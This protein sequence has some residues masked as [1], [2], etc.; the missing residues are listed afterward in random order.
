MAIHKKPFGPRVG[1]TLASSL[2]IL[3]SLVASQAFAQ[4]SATEA[5]AA[6]EE[7][8]VTGTR[9]NLQNAQD[10]KRDSST[11]VDVISAEDIG[12]L[13]DRSVLEAM[14]RLPGVSIERFAGPDDPDHFSVEG[15]GAVIRGMSATRS[16]FNGRDSFTANSG[17]GLSFQDVSPELMGGVDVYKNQTADMIEGGIGG[18]VSL[19]TRKPFDQPDQVIAISGDVS[20]GDM[21]E[22]SSP[23]ISGLYSNQWDTDAGRFGVLFNAANSRL[24]GVSHGIQ[25]DAFVRYDATVIPGAERFVDPITG[26]GSVWMPNGANLLM[27]HDDRKRQGYAFATQWESPDETLLG[28][29]QY[30]RSDSTLAWTENA[31]KYQGGYYDPD[32]AVD[33]RNTRPYGDTQFEF[34]DQGLFEQGYLSDSEGWRVANDNVDHIPRSWGDN[35]VGKFGHK[36][37]SETRYKET[38][39]LVEDFSFNFAWTPNEQWE[40]SV[41]FQYIE[42]ETRDD[43]LVVHLGI[44]A[45]QKY[46]I[47]GSTPSLE[48]VEPWGGI[49]DNARA[50]DP[51][52]Y[53]QPPSQD[54]DGDGTP[55][56]VFTDG[57]PGFTGD[58]AGDTN[59]F[60]DPNSYWWRSAMDHFERSD[61]DSFATRFDTKYHFED[62]DILRSV[63]GGIRFAEREQT[64]RSTSWNWGSV[65]PEFSGGN[66]ALWLPSV[67]QQANDYEYVDWSDFHGGGVLTL[68]GNQLI[69]P[70]EQFVKDLL[71]G[72]REIVKNGGGNWTPY[73]NRTGLDDQFNLFEPA[74]IYNTT[75]ANKALYVRLDFGSDG[76][77]R[78]DGNIGLRYV[79]F[80]RNALGSIE[81]PDLL[82]EP[83]FEVPE[84]TGLSSPLTTDVVAAYMQQQVDEGTYPNVTEALRANPWATEARNYLD[85]TSMDFGNDASEL[86]EATSKY[87]T[88]LPSFNI[89][90]EMTDDVIMRFAAAKAIALPDMDQVR[91]QARLGVGNV[92][93]IYPE[94]DPDNPPADDE[95]RG[96]LGAYV[97]RWEGDGGNPYLKPMESV[98]YDL[99]LEWY[100]ADVGQLTGT[101]FHK[102]LT[103]FFIYGAFPQTYTNPETNITRTVDVTGTRNGGDG[104]MDGFEIAYQQFFDMLPEPWDGFGIQANYTYIDA[105]GVPNN[106]VPAEEADFVGGDGDTGARVALSDV[107]LQGQSKETANLVAM[108]E[109]YGWS[110]RIAYNWRSRYLLTTRDVI[111]KYPLWN[112]DAGFMDASVFYSVTDNIQLGL[113]ITNLLDQTS[114]TIMILDGKGL[115]TGR[116]WFTQDRRAALVF[117][118]NF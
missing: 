103:N 15:S 4:E 92:E 87:R 89:K 14:Q 46:S 105:G 8:I 20:Y 36:F 109:K 84:S 75:E 81:F 6:V 12:S 63:S 73:R 67:P 57:Y 86:L 30:L 42:A 48:L 114:K 61:G 58:P 72:R 33:K 116:S 102:S 18:T 23:T 113:Q 118:A 64:V 29:F 45:L 21:A 115:E 22:K 106:E 100:F 38:R 28:T 98:Q 107:P 108:Y 68:P 32:N 35:A 49:R 25:S 52:A 112:D 70:T 17:R 24:Y 55:D 97:D 94:I 2:T 53:S 74:E 44:N 69:H 37:Q 83:G 95:P 79:H 56:I 1:I 54:N 80:E 7:V 62:S 59:Y 40:S 26:E 93:G 117:R 96:L 50:E 60:Q 88:V 11:V 3:T 5:P 99:A 9:Q 10:L 16:E 27:K 91:N 51:D 47:L 34:D 111:S 104:T 85:Q 77:L 66:P 90:V 78:F 13:P 65:G 110:A 76:D 31:F 101:L 41:D 39:T 19:R 43:D 82:P 71:Q